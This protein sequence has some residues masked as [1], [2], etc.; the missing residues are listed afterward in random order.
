MLYMVFGNRHSY[1]SPAA[2]VFNNT[3]LAVAAEPDIT[4]K[5]IAPAVSLMMLYPNVP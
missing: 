3:V 5:D 2:N 1:D 4:R